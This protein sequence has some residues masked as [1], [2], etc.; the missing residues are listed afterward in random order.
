MVARG[1]SAKDQTSIDLASGTRGIPQAWAMV[2]S[3]K[4]TTMCQ[5]GLP[6]HSEID[7]S[8]QV[9]GEIKRGQLIC[10]GRV[11]PIKKASTQCALVPIALSC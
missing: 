8:I 4:L 9:G 2:T 5:A 1:L 3:M 7:E 10:N 11:K 6:S